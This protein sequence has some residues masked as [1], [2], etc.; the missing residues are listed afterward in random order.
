MTNSN[1]VA[2]VYDIGRGVIKGEVAIVDAAISLV[3]AVIG[4][5]FHAVERT[6]R[7]VF[8]NILVLGLIGV[9]LVAF[10]AYQQQ[11]AKGRVGTNSGAGRKKL[12]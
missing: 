9:A 11:Q 2:A 3:R 5:G 12:A 6:I 7:L 10:N 4:E 1:I 8:A